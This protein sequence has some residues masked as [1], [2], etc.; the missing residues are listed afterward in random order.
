MVPEVEP[1]GRSLDMILLFLL[2]LFAWV[3]WIPQAG[4]RLGLV[5]TAAPLQSP[6]NVLAAWSPGLAAVLLPAVFPRGPG[7]RGLLGRLARWYAGAILLEAARW[8][9]PLGINRVLG[10]SCEPGPMPVREDLTSA[11]G[12][13]IVVAVVFTL[14]NAL[15]EETGWRGFALPGL[16]ARRGPPGGR[17]G[18]RGAPE[19]VAHACV[20]G[21]GADVGPRRRRFTW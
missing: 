15:G 12:F 10:R 4:Y 14:P 18:A 1:R 11:P 13:M 6:V 7:V 16:R 20:G 21:A 9:L 17:P 2:N 5:E 3:I 19:S 8:G